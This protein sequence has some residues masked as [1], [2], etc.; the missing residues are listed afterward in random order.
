MPRLS[1]QAEALLDAVGEDG[2]STTL[3]PRRG[4][5]RLL[6]GNLGNAL[7]TSRPWLPYVWFAPV[8]SA[9]LEVAPP[10]AEVGVT[11]PIPAMLA[12]PALW[13]SGALAWMLLEYLMHRFFFHLRG[14]GRLVRGFRFLVH[15]HHHAHPWDERR[16]AAT[17]WQMSLAMLLLFGIERA[18]APVLWPHVFLGSLVAYLLYEAI[19]H[20][21]HHDQEGGRLL[22]AIRAHHLRHHHGPDGA[23][24]GYGISSPVFDWL[25]RT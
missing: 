7:W 11:V 6:P 10:A 4:H 23:K 1:D 18:L 2:Q 24:R 8:V 9:C 14:D 17:W 15:E 3:K 20:R 5:V 21:I 13:L 25:F 12:I 16:I 19:H 22:R